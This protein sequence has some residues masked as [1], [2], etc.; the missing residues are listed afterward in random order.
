MRKTNSLN[1]LEKLVLSVLTEYIATHNIFEIGGPAWLNGLK[2][3]LKKIVIEFTNN[4]I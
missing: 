1:Y 3:V 4:L 2:P